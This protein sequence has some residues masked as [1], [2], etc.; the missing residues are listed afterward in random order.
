MIDLMSSWEDMTGQSEGADDIPAERWS[1]SSI[2]GGGDRDP[3]KA[4]AQWEWV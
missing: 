3:A 2:I 4:Q 1:G